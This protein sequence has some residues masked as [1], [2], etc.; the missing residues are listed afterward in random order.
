MSA[1]IVYIIEIY[2]VGEMRNRIVEVPAP[3]FTTAVQILATWR[4]GVT[5]IK[6]HN[7]YVEGVG[8]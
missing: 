1:S 6:L 4:P 3:D 7:S 5:L 2:V 8:T